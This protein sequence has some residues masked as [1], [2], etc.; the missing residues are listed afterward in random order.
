MTIAQVK[1]T[2]PT[3]YTLKNSKGEIINGSYYK[4]EIQKAQ[5]K[6]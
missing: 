2:N 3:T 5:M 6:L 1:D 4:Y